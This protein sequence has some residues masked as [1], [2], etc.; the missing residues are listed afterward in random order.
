[1]KLEDLQKIEDKLGE[2]RTILNPID[3]PYICDTIINN[4]N[5]KMLVDL[6]MNMMIKMG[7]E[8]KKILQVAKIINQIQT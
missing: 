8:N 1:M 3:G 5:D 4:I 2:I 6:I 7:Y